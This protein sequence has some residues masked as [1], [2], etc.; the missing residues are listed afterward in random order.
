M[1]NDNRTTNNSDHDEQ[2][3]ETVS[4]EVAEHA[5]VLRDKNYDAFRR[6][7]QL[8]YN[9]YRAQ[10]L[11][12][13]DNKSIVNEALALAEQKKSMVTK[14]DYKRSVDTARK[15]V[16]CKKI[17][18]YAEDI[19]VTQDEYDDLSLSYFDDLI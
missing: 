18:E 16:D 13:S 7:G 15:L 9:K 14:K 12:E 17:K 8:G 10:L 11:K 2:K 5:T 3:S 4:K 19:S 1:R 6:G